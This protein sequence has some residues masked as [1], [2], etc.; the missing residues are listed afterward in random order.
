ML[1]PLKLV[2]DQKLQQQLYDQLHALIVSGGLAAGTRMPSTRALADQFAISRITVL[3]AYERLIAEGLLQ[4][5]PAIGT[6]VSHDVVLRTRASGDAVQPGSGPTADA[7]SEIRA[8]RPD[9]TL[10][11]AGR[12][13]VLARGALDQLVSRAHNRPAGGHPA[14]RMAVTKWLAASRGLSVLPDQVLLVSGRR[15]ALHIVAHLLMAAGSRAVVEDPCED[16]AAALLSGAGAT[17][18][19]VGVDA[20][21]LRT[22]LLPNGP[23]A[24]A[25]ITPE[26]HRPLGGILS[27]SRRQS[28]LDWARGAD[29]TI[30]VEDC[31]S[32][33]RYEPCSTPPMMALDQ[34]ARV[35]HIGSFATTL[36]P[37]LTLGFMIV[38]RALVE[39]ALEARQLVDDHARWL[40]E[41]ALAGLIDSGGF[42]RHVHRVRKIYQARR[43]RLVSLMRATF[44]PDTQ[45]GGGRAG[46]HLTWHLPTAFGSAADVAA[47]ARRCGLDASVGGPQIVLVGFGLPSEHQIPHAVSRLGALLQTSVAGS[48]LF[49][50]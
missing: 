16:D 20:E 10:F 29:A 15:Q 41:E 25:L 34:D 43:D 26:S 45:L 47:L 21:G 40:E 17:L 3:L 13:R 28:L 38:P 48:A 6:F 18:V 9:P 30:V 33:L 35:V 22:D 14:L 4:T 42:A 50:D 2:R 7:V 37:I 44:G 39:A 12:W 46:L 49:A 8:G 24:L 1:I 23:V 36:G 27:A 32:D 5:L 31:D 19:R 11:P